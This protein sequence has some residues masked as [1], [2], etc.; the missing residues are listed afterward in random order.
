MRSPMCSRCDEIDR[1]IER[2]RNLA[3]RITD[4]QTLDGIAVLIAELETRK[5]ELHTQESS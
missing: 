5:G 3:G 4:Q 2:L 1:K